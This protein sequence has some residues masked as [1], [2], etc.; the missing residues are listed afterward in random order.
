MQI[1]FVL[2]P[3][4]K[5]SSIRKNSSADEAGAKKGD[6][7]ISVNGIDTHNLT[8]EKINQLLKSE[9]G[10]FIS[11]ELERNG[12]PMKIKFQLKKII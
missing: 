7:I 8:I 5:I 3:V 2:K 12:I 11:M 10:K 4:F 6:R 1:R 9:E